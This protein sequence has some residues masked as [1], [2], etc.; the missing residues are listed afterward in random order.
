MSFVETQAVGVQWS[1]L[2]TR[3]D[4]ANSLTMGAVWGMFIVEMIIYGFITW[5]IDAIN[6]GQYGVAKKWYFLFQVRKQNLI[7]AS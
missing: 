1:N 7:Q 2:F 3:S 5:Y 4:P 6:P